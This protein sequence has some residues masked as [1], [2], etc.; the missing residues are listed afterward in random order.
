MSRS[1]T[2]GH[3]AA[4]FA[5]SSWIALGFDTILR[6]VPM[7]YRDALWTVPFVATAVAFWFVHRV[8]RTPAN[9]SE[10]LAF[11]TLMTVCA[12]M[13]AGM[14]GAIGWN[15]VLAWFG[16]ATLRAGVFPKYVGIS[17]ILLE[18]G[19]LL[20]GIALSPIA[21][22]SGHGAYSAGIEKGAVLAILACGFR[23]VLASDYRVRNAD[24]QALPMAGRAL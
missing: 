8:Q 19:S 14:A 2:A 20:T 17:L 24:R 21:P 4:L 9:R 11:W 15:L 18:P 5:A 22:L 3:R 7:D 1:A 23:A 12:A 6:P 16:I 13:L 10:R